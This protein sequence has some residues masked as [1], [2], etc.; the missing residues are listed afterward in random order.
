MTSGRP[1]RR[2]R[3]WSMRAWPMSSKP[4]S[5]KGRALICSVAASGVTP[6]RWTWARSSSKVDLSMGVSG[7]SVVGVACV[8]V[9]RAL[10]GAGG[11]VGLA[12]VAAADLVAVD[13]GGDGGLLD[14]FDRDVVG[15]GG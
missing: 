13:P 5:A 6:P 14:L 12:A 15:G 4:A 1:V 11:G 8:D 2:A 10:G 7:I 3:W 9:D